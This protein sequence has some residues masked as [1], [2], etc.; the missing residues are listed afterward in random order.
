MNDARLARIGVGFFAT[1]AVAALV[2]VAIAPLPE[3]R[4]I[5]LLAGLGSAAGIGLQL[6]VL[7]P[8]ARAAL[9]RVIE[10]TRRH[11][12]ALAGFAAERFAAWRALRSPPPAPAAA[13]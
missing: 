6:L 13:S 10:D 2:A 9:D 11:A 8:H 1:T 7:G 3:I 12:R 5:A 4:T